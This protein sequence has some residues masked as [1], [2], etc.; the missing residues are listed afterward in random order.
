ML[1][2][3]ALLAA[4]AVAVSRQVSLILENIRFQ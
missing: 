3:P 1:V 2:L 4:L